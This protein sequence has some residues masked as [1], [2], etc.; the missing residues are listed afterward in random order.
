M[1][2]NLFLIRANLRRAKG[3]AVA[4]LVLILLAAGMMNLWL[5]LSLDYRQNFIRCHGRLHGEHVT[6]CVEGDAHGMQEYISKVLK[7]DGRVTETCMDSVMC[8]EG[9]ITY[10]GG[11][12]TTNFILM[13]KNNALGR[14]IGKSELV[15]DTGANEGIYLPMIYKTGEIAAGKKA[16]LTIGSRK[17][18]YTVCGFFNN[19]MLGSHNC[20]MCLVLLTEQSYQELKGQGYAPEATLVSVRMKGPTGSE[21][22]EALLN[23]AI[24][25]KYPERFSTS[26]SYALVSQSR[27]ISQMICSGVLSAM[28]FF[29]LLIVLVVVASNI[30]NYIQENM[31]NLGVWKAMGYQ[32]R[33]LVGMLLQQFLG[34]AFLGTFVGVALSYCLFP[35]LNGMMVSQT[36]IPYEVR[37]L[38]VPFLATLAVLCGTVAFAVWLPARRIQKIPPIDALRQGIRTHSFQR[39]HIPL[40]GTRLPL[41]AALSLKT[42]LS[43]M[44]YNLTICITMMVLSLMLVFSGLM[45]E[46]V[47]V[48]MAP[49]RNLVLGE[50]ADTCININAGA[51]AEFLQEMEQ[52]SRVEKRYLYH[53]QAVEHVEGAG[54]SP[55]ESADVAGQIKGASLLANICDDFSKVN[56]QEVII[57]GRFPEFENEAAI[58]VKYA[59][60]QGIGL[61]DE[62][63][64]GM[65]EKEAVYLISGFTQISNNLGKDCLLTREGYGRIGKLENLS[66]CMNLSPDVSV[67]RFNQE[68]SG[69]FGSKVNKAQNIEEII[70]GTSAV[71]VSLMTAIV[72]AILILSALIAVFVMFLLVRSIL[73]NKRV[74]YGVLKA[75]GFTTAQLMAQTALSFLPAVAASAAVGLILSSFVINPLIAIFLRDLGIVSCTFHVPVGFVAAA[76][77]GLVAFAFAAACLM[78]LR[79]KRIVPRSLLSSD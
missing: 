13:E 44:K 66:Y 23:H 64:L 24:S 12:T 55:A 48:D 74:E 41:T 35:A 21:A 73:G 14:S 57:E 9:G 65:G 28:A 11:E 77:V 30:I 71:Y 46:N 8:A 49:F 10:N 6:A 36:G 75:I 70:R 18:S 5:M 63:R 31:K 40:E 79:I 76:G 45:L 72:A 25:A 37:F 19:A 50:T 3:Q 59:R 20:G 60:E 56:N 29:V 26:N 7:E 69:R 22:V 17:V 53:T 32:S 39:N 16:V 2:K 1:E 38:P 34:I 52:D 27:Y 47:I 62:I 58:A 4:E 15:E 54:V 51:E 42:T 67:D 33:Q 43:G 78:S 68:I 61:G